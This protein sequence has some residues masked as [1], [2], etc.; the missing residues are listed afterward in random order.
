MLYFAMNLKNFSI[1]CNIVSHSVVVNSRVLEMG[2]SIM[3]D[4][5]IVEL[6]YNHDDKGLVETKNKYDGLLNILSF[7]IVRND[8]DVSEC[9]NDTYLKV[10]DSIPPHRPDNFK[11]F[12]C[13]LVRQI[14][15]DKYRYNHRKNRYKEGDIYLSELDYDIKSERDIDEELE[16]RLLVGKLNKFLSE[17]KTENRVL[18]MRKYFLFEDSKSLAKRYG[19]SENTI[20]VRMLRIRNK[21]QKYLESEGYEFE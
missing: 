6:L 2:R 1:F 14:S 16:N 21:L 18:F 19:I 4:S 11:S 3:E 5:N 15:I 9:V 10:W 17:L 12:I 7:R 8:S 13:K 20:N